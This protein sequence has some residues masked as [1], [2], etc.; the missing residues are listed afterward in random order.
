MT[1]INL[2][3]SILMAVLEAVQCV[4][5][6]LAFHSNINIILDDS[7]FVL[8]LMLLQTPLQLRCGSTDMELK[9]LTGSVGGRDT[10]I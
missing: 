5:R 10:A 9:H 8:D 2:G 6:S 1:G 7:C 3:T 4:L